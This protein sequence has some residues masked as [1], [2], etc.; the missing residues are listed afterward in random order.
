MVCGLAPGVA[1]QESAAVLTARIVDG[2][3]R[4]VPDADV[5]VVQLD[6]TLRSG[7]NGV[8]RLAPVPAGQYTVGVRKVGHLPI[9]A[10]ITAGVGTTPID[11]ELVALTTRIAPV[12]TTA[13]RGGLSGVVSDTALRPLARAQVK[14]AGSGRS[15]QTDSAGRFFIDLRPGTYMV[16]VVRDSFA[17]QTLA[18]TIPKDSG[19]EIAV[20]L[21]PRDA[22][23]RAEEA[24]EAARLFDLDQKMIR[25]SQQSSRYFS[26][27]QL[28]AL[29]ITD[30]F[31]LANRWASGSI[32]ADCTVVVVNEGGAPYRVP[33][34]SVVTDDVEFVE[35]Y[36]LGARPRQGSRGSSM[37]DVPSMRCGNL[38]INVW[39]RR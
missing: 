36:M 14:P 23:R 28:S 33:L 38:S 37:S 26:R 4:P 3:G 6:R 39:L 17:R 15:A 32:T 9:S 24:V 11:I 34:N 29:G 30:M 13:Q 5:F 31:R 22:R 10:T 7:Q 20:W 25:A 35:L 12:V 16:S 21:S 27:D 8:V 19:R 18:V 2:A 1:A